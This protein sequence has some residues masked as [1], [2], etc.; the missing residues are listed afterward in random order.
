MASAA[1]ARGIA[2]AL[3]NRASTSLRYRRFRLS[4]CSAVAASPAS[5]KG[6]MPSA[7]SHCQ[8]CGAVM[9]RPM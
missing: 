4:I 1:S 8:T 5:R 7:R 2:V 6:A 9:D 3:I